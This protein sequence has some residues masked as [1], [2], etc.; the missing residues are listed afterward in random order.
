MRESDEKPVKDKKSRKR[1]PQPESEEEPSNSAQNK[2]TG[3][4]RVTRSNRA[5]LS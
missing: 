2:A 4:V 3:P 5:R 1:L